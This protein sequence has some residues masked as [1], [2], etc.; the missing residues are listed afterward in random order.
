MMTTSGL[1]MTLVL[2]VA[3]YLKGQSAITE[4]KNRKKFEVIFVLG[5]SPNTRYFTTIKVFNQFK[6]LK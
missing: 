2:H 1:V 4:K 3:N 5:V 6:P